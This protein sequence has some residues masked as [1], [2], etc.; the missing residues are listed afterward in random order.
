M[1]RP[2]AGGALIHAATALLPP[3]R[4]DSLWP[5]AVRP[6]PAPSAS[7]TV[8]DVH[9]LPVGHQLNQYRIE[10]VIGRGGFGITYQAQD[11]T[12]RKQVAVKE[13]LPVEFAVRATDASV[14]ARARRLEQDYR[15]GLERFLDE[16]RTLAHFRHPNLVPVLLFFEAN[17]TAY[18]VMEFER[19]RSLADVIADSPSRR[20][21]IPRLPALLDG[22]LS[23]LVDVHAAG[24]LHRD[25]K[26]ANIILR[27]DGTAVLVD[28][29]SARHAIGQRS[30]TLTSIVTPRYAPIEQYALE[31]KQGP[32][33]DL[34]GVAAVLYHLI[35]SEAPPEAVNRVRDDPYRPLAGRTDV[36]LSRTLLAAI[37][38]A[39]APYPEQ[40]PQS[41]A[42]F[43]AMAGLGAPSAVPV[44]GPPDENAPTRVLG[45]PAPAAAAAAAE[46]ES[47]ARDVA[48]RALRPE[49]R[50]MLRTSPRPAGMRWTGLALLL[51]AGFGAGA[52]YWNFGL[53]W[54]KPP[55][56]VVATPPPTPTPTPNPTPPT[57]NPAP[58]VANPTPPTPTPP[59]PTPPKDRKA[60]Q[61]AAAKAAL[62]K[63]RQQ[64]I[65]EASQTALI[66]RGQAD[67]AA[68]AA[69]RARQRAGAARLRAAEAAK[70][71]LEGAER[72]PYGDGSVYVG[73][74]VDGRR[75]GLGVVELPSGERQAGEWKDD[76]LNGLAVLSL[77]DGRRYEGE[78]KM[79]VRDGYGIL[80]LGEGD[81]V[82]GEQGPN[83]VNG[84]AVWRSRDGTERFGQWRDG[85]LEGPGV[86][87]VGGA[88]YEGEFRS[89]V[90]H[91]KG[92]LVQSDGARYHGLF[93][94]GKREGYGVETR[95]D[96]SR[97]GQW[98]AGVL[99]RP[100]Q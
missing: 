86:E 69:E 3:Q 78:W 85:K 38:A 73:Q 30:R 2:A 76:R 48:F 80:Q 28:F 24:F 65:N 87:I 70:P 20:A 23:A 31:G 100:E 18:M 56:V 54:R 97:S 96:G 36:A 42:A 49:D 63:K 34:Y 74:L 59:T 40:R 45:E 91:G 58:P 98:S 64:A 15:W 88:K 21:L 9:A 32:W 14:Q 77:P 44:P 57:P 99:S 53:P 29:G 62:E 22:L 94:D 72:V 16:A 95:A 5:A 84:Y 41:V 60:E 79:Q 61:E 25:I 81:Q 13:Y 47:P 92:M 33:S 46:P 50:I 7:M 66:A 71:D 39:L 37:D 19:G 55:E 11:T 90:Q 75:N 68:A 43:R 89:G 82:A 35:T 4:H 52:Y 10:A 67:R 26:P 1:G 6:L 8:D 93:A 12:L 51:V 83:A 17:G 27:P